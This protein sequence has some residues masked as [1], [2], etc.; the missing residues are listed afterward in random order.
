MASYGKKP[1]IFYDQSGGAGRGFDDVSL[2][3]A[4]TGF[5]AYPMSEKATSPGLSGHRQARR[6]RPSDR[7][8]LLALTLLAAFTKLYRIGRR[9]NVSWDEAHFGKFGAY[10]LNRTFYMDVHP[11]L[12]KLLV[13]FSELLAGH[14]GSFNFKGGQPY[15]AFVHYGFMRMFNAAF[16]IALTPM[17]FL[18]CRQLRMPA[19]F[20]AMAALF[21]TLDNAICVMSRF[22]LL[23]APLLAF[24]ALSLT[25]LAYFYRQRAAPF[26]PAWWKYLLLTGLSLGLVSSAKWVGLF[27]VALVGFYTVAELFEMFCN[28]RMPVRV[29][30]KHWIARGIA[31]IA[32]PLFVYMLCFKIHF[33]ILN[34][35]DGSA[36]FM[37]VGF[38]VKLHGNPI[39][40]QPYEIETG[41]GVRLQSSLG[42]SGYLHSHVHKYPAGS[43]R[44]QVTGYGFADPNN[45]WIMKR[46][47]AAGTFS[48]AASVSA[49]S[50]PMSGPIAHG[51]LVALYHNSTSTYLYSD[52]AHSAPVGDRFKEVST[53]DANS[54][55]ANNANTLWVVEVVNPESR[56]DD[57]FIHPLG[58]PIRLRS[59]LRDCV[60]MSTGERLDK[61]WGWGQAEMACDADSKSTRRGSKYLWTIERH[62]NPNMTKTNLGKFMSSSFLRDFGVLNRQMWLTNNA[63]IPDHDKHNVL[64]SDPTSW[65][66]LVYPMR[67]VGWDDTSIKYMEMGNVLLWYGSAMACL[68]FPLQVLYWLVCWQRKRLN[69]RMSEFREY[70]EG[71][72]MLWMGWMFHY[73]PFY[74]MGRVTYLHH[75]LPALYFGILFLAYQIYHVSSWYMGNNN[76]QAP[77]RVVYVSVAAVAFVFWWF[78][79]LTYGW[80]KPINDLKGMEWV[81]SWPVYTDKLA[82]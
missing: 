23:D 17:A 41:S 78:S 74:A 39:A 51:D 68:V 76:R 53:V 65:P 20:A 33:S 61:S 19:A 40:R 50:E 26:S 73:M 46:K 4:P 82:L 64:E 37:P 2:P 69:W 62:I 18:T 25:M 16:G 47:A 79:P 59:I 44:Q 45:I 57:G 38:Q 80:D 54:P 58:T 43:Q 24:T 8:I 67:L 3:P 72:A 7:A 77:L 35:Y 31:L 66:F 29:Y 13:G 36:N 21:V 63:L 28:T 9:S 81:P 49:A 42:G 52:T 34:R 48:D 71:A 12:A 27:A 11:P 30:T 1:S 32:V 15:P 56:M 10:Y 6:A 22:I 55:L 5:N 14:N 60:L 75:Y 70:F